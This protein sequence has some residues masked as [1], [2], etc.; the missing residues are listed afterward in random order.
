PN[1]L[2]LCWMISAEISAEPGAASIG[3]RSIF[4]HISRH[5]LV[6]LRNQRQEVGFHF[7]L[8]PCRALAGIDRA[9]KATVLYLAVDRWFGV[10]DALGPE[11]IP[12]EQPHPRRLN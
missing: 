2:G 4:P 3:L 6:A 1:Q 7:R 8:N 12:A 10:L 11:V 5:P 9:R